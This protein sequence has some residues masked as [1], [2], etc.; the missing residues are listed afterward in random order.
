MWSAFI[1]GRGIGIDSYKADANQ[2]NANVKVIGGDRGEAPNC[3]VDFWG[4]KCTWA[5]Q[6]K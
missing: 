2:Q 3:P 6:E 4:T 5:W 1:Q